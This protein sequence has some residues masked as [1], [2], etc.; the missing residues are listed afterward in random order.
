M[1]LLSREQPMAI[2][3]VPDGRSALRLRE[4]LAV[5]L[6]LALAALLLGGAQRHFGDGGLMAGVALAAFADAHSPVASLASLHA[7]G[8]L[9]AGHFVSGAMLAVGA[10]TLTRCTVA[11]IAGGPRYA[12]RVAA[13]LVTSMG[14]AAAAW[15]AIP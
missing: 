8:N 14:C 4:A 1:P 11:A 2:E 12:L 3:A 13:A 15:F 6:A 9:S 10:N 5:A 7:A